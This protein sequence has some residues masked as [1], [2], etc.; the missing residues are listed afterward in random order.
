MGKQQKYLFETSDALTGYDINRERQELISKFSDIVLYSLLRVKNKTT[1]KAALDLSVMS[2]CHGESYSDLEKLTELTGLITDEKLAIDYIRGELR[3]KKSEMQNGYIDEDKIVNL[4]KSD[5]AENSEPVI[6]VL[7][8]TSRKA[9]GNMDSD[10]IFLA[11][12]KLIKA[13]EEQSDIENFPGLVKNTLLAMQNV[14]SK[15]S[16]FIRTYKSMRSASNDLTIRSILRNE[17]GANETHIVRTLATI[18]E[19]N[20]ANEMFPSWPKI[21]VEKSENGK[22]IGFQVNLDNKSGY[23]SIVY[24]KPNDYNLIANF[25]VQLKDTIDDS[26]D[27]RGSKDK[28]PKPSIMTYSDL[29][30]CVVGCFGFAPQFIPL[31]KHDIDELFREFKI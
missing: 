10:D 4:L 23:F 9:Y 8:E 27:A 11:A 29:G 30:V 21:I 12:Q 22:S 18:I 13:I 2:R 19:N 5:L 24:L 15:L 7:L 17:L 26:Y 1:L 14:E 25:V 16:N 31:V 28:I 3:I 6:N 20:I